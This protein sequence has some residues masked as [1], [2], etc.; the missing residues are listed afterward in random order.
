MLHVTTGR[1]P[2]GE[3]LCQ[4]SLGFTELK[5]TTPIQSTS[6]F[7]S[8]RSVETRA[9]T[10]GLK[11]DCRWRSPAWLLLCDHTLPTDRTTHLPATHKS[12][13]DPQ[14]L[15]ASCDLGK[16]YSSTGWEVK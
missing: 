2:V 6:V 11:W 3:G 12:S 14:P 5:G 8:H 1:G 7:L 15:Q 10:Q 13:P 4:H 9:Q 16:P